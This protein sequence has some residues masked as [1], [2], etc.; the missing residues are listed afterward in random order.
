MTPWE[1]N[2]WLQEAEPGGQIIYHMGL[3][4]ADKE[5]DHTLNQL[6]KAAWEAY[7]ADEVVLVQ[8]HHFETGYDA[9][10]DASIK[11]KIHSEYIAIKI[12]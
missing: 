11:K 3:L 8:R 1:F 12:P 2:T 4:A 7:R 5:S 6:A 10:M 9:T